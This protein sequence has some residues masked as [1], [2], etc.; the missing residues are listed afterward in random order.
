MGS[1]AVYAKAPKIRVVPVQ[2]KTTR[3]RCLRRDETPRVASSRARVSHAEGE[4]PGQQEQRRPV[5]DRGRANER[6]KPRRDPE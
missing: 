6:A 1:R 4:K 3:T 2:N 5:G